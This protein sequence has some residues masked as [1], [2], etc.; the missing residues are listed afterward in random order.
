MCAVYYPPNNSKYL[1]K[2]DIDLLEKLQHDISFYKDKGDIILCGD[3]NA[4]TACNLDYIPNDNPAYIPIHENYISD[5]TIINRRSM[6]QV[7]D[8]R[9]RDLL[10]FCITNQLRILN[11][12]SFG[13]MYG[14]FTCHNYHSAS[15]VD[16]CITSESFFSK[17][18]SFNVS[19]FSPTL[20]DCHCQLTFEMLSHHRVKKDNSNKVSNYQEKP[21]FIWNSL[22]PTVFLNSLNSS[23]IQEK[24]KSFHLDQTS[25][26]NTLAENLTSLIYEA[27]KNVLR[28]KT[29]KKPNTK[30]R[31]RHK[32]W[33][34]PDLIKM[35]KR[36][37]QFGKIFSNNNYVTSIRDK[38]YRMLREYNKLKRNKCREYKYRILNQIINLHDKDPK[39][40]W[41]LINDLK[42]EQSQELSNNITPQQWI[43]H[44]RS[45][46]KPSNEF[47]E[48]IEEINS[49]LKTMKSTTTQNTL[50]SPI[51]KNEIMK[52]ISQ[53][54]SNKSVGPD[55]ISNE[56][57]KCGRM[58]LLPY[59]SKVFN[60]CIKSESYPKSWAE[61]SITPIYKSDNVDDPNNYRGISISSSIG[62]IFN[63]IMYSRLQKFLNENSIIDPCQIGF[64][65]KARTSDHMFILKCLLDKYCAKS[66]KLYAC[67]VDLRKAFDS[68]IHP[69]LRYK[70]KL[71][72]VGN[73]FY[74]II[75]DM[76][77]KSSC[78]IKTNDTLSDMFDLQLGVKQGDSLSSSLFNI[79]VN[80]LPNYLRTTIDPVYLL[81]ER[82]DCLM[83]A[84][85]L[86]LLSPTPAGLQQKID[87]L[88]RYCSDWCLNVNLKKTKILVFNKAG[89]HINDQ[90][91]FKNDIIQHASSY[92]YLGLNFTLSGSFKQSENELVNKARKAYFKL[93]KDFFSFN[94]NIPVSLH[95]FDHTIKPILMY[96]SEIWGTFRTDLPKF[97]NG[98]IDLDK[99]Y[100]TSSADSFHIKFCK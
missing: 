50:G 12:R 54:K 48:R 34:D 74:N 26:C 94:P 39:S 5:Q 83:Y 72:G 27:A 79:Y 69:G 30:K 78:R 55:K 68:V 18:L 61:S 31:P 49:A 16:Y 45:L 77:K 56:M 63:S 38:Y 41:K 87:A 22:S 42:D 17:I 71:L 24:L 19:N 93:R 29:P 7:I 52:A 51:T 8:K 33:F 44:F 95:V 1:N 64:M 60:A 67:F 35:R 20:S 43:D 47:A 32:K 70:L 9:G 13:D 37:M 66:G 11:G 46:S 53:L 28:T 40:Y 3:F 75:E 97:R 36:L 86:V 85:D 62:K 25:N 23:C 15:V 90:F 82:L 76:Y 81:T 91:N 21:K 99:I 65:K 59:L 14:K 89:R 88:S 57:L 98:T 84:D 4:R 92:R 58:I 6:D 100:Q 73:T 10:E 96:G 2:D 80:D